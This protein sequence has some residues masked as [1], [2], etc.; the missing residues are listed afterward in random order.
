MHLKKRQ[1]IDALM[2]L[3]GDS[4]FVRPIRT[5]AG[6]L[7]KL[8][9]VPVVDNED[10][11]RKLG[12]LIRSVKLAPANTL[13]VDEL[14]EC[15]YSGLLVPPGKQRRNG[16]DVAEVMLADLSPEQVYAVVDILR[17]DGE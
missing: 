5:R 17:Q 13:S 10:L 8:L 12:A 4:E 6:W 3:L 14:A 11:N 7:A 16:T 1:A 15:L 9:T 2:L